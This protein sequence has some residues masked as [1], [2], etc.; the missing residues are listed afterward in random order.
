MYVCEMCLTSREEHLLRLF[1]NS[2]LRK[3]TN[4]ENRVL[5]EKLIVPQIVKKLPA[6]Y[7]TRGFIT[8]STVAHHVSLS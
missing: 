7:A 4:S 3:I 8:E 6:F 1:E 5:L 2:V